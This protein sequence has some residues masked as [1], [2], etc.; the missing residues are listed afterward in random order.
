[1]VSL[2]HPSLPP[3]DLGRLEDEET[4]P[5]ERPL[6]SRKYAKIMGQQF[7]SYAR[8]PRLSGRN[9]VC[10]TLHPTSL[11]PT[12]V[13]QHIPKNLSQQREEKKGKKEDGIPNG[14]R[15]PTANIGDGNVFYQ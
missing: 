14:E 15:I 2:G 8:R 9:S 5:G 7:F 12:Q 6:D 13:E 1:M 3:T 11:G 10:G 4:S